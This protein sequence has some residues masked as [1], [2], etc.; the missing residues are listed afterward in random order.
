MSDQRLDVKK[1]YK[2]LINGAFP[3]SESGR[4]Y[5]VTSFKGAFLAN[6]SQAS[7]KDVRD[8][9]VAARAAQTKWWAQ[10]A[11]NRGQ[12]IYRLAEMAESR[13]EELSEHVSLARGPEAEGSAR[14]RRPDDRPRGVVR[15]LDRQGRPG[16]W[17]VESGG[18]TLLQLFGAGAERGGGRRRRARFLAGGVRGRRL[19]PDRRRERGGGAS[20]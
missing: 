1:T 13:R 14:R 6:V 4:S 19:R 16:T 3:R 11:Y 20:Q 17:F 7:R 12:V 18:R 8:A 15:G 2:L 5:E 10:S 9:V